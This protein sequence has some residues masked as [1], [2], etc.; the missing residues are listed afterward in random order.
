M[1]DRA[2]PN[3]PARDFDETEAFYAKLGFER[4]WRDGG[5]MILRRDDVQLEFFPHPDLDPAE[6]SFGCCL[7]L[8]DMPAF[9]ETC[10]AA[11]IGPDPAGFPRLQAPQREHS[12]LDIAYLVD[13][14][15]SLLRLVQN[16]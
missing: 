15:G 4:S 7:R 6:S 2:T 12:G 16:V 5:W 3:L 10:R 1:A 8:D 14:D 11:G 13:P 9:V